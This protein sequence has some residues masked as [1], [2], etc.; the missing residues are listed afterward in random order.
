MSSNLFMADLN[1]LVEVK[2]VVVTNCNTFLI[3]YNN[4]K[5]INIK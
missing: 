1:R 2:N 5:D 4:D 3:K